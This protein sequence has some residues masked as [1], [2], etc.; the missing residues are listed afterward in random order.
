[1]PFLNFD[2]TASRK[3][4]AAIVKDFESGD[5]KS[6]SAT[7]DLT[8]KP[9]ISRGKTTNRA[10]RGKKDVTKVFENAMHSSEHVARKFSESNTFN[11]AREGAYIY[12]LNRDKLP[13]TDPAAYGKEN[14]KSQKPL[15]HQ[16]KYRM[17]FRE[18]LGHRHGSLHIS[19]TLNQYFYNSIGMASRDEDQVVY[20]FMR[21]NRSPGAIKVAIAEP[22][23]SVSPLDEA[24]EQKPIKEVPVEYNDNPRIFTVD[25]M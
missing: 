6:C 5:K 18:Y 3:E 8:Q 16:E 2:T 22:E 20:R 25:Q 21:E 10:T 17:L 13:T 9:N 24:T 11:L 7:L 1:M 15:G 14:D 12:A 4:I 23:D 19:R